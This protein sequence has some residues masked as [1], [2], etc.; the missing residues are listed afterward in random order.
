MLRLKPHI[1]NGV[2]YEKTY[3]LILYPEMFEYSHIKTIVASLGC[4]YIVILH[5]KDIDDNGLPKKDHYHVLLNFDNEHSI[6][7]VANVFQIGSQLID[8]KNN[9]KESAK[10]LFHITDRAIAQG[11]FRYPFES[12]FTNIDDLETWLTTSASLF[13]QESEELKLLLGYI[14]EFNVVSSQLLLEFALENG[15]TST[16]RR[17]YSL[18][19]ECMKEQKGVYEIRSLNKTYHL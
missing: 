4:R 3:S 6:N 18:L 7:S 15:F 9:F 5:D 17:N 2:I 12:A 11:K 1:K 13:S 14:Q 19:R 10:Y 16:L 8:W